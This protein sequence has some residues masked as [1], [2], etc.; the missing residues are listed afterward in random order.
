MSHII[1]GTDGDFSTG[2]VIRA[3][4]N[5][6]VFADKSVIVDDDE[7]EAIDTLPSDADWI[8]HDGV[9]VVE[10]SADGE[11]STVD[12]IRASGNEIV[13]AEKSVI[14]DD[15]EEAIDTLTSGAG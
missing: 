6:T 7:A 3:S 15:D 13:L 4:D 9:D 12:V 5:E 10:Y 14:V 2:D 1:L 8:D 11:F